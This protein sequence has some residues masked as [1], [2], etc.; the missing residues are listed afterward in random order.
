MGEETNTVADAMAFVD[1]LD[2]YVNPI[3]NI[4]GG[5]NYAPDKLP[6]LLQEEIVRAYNTA[7]RRHRGDLRPKEKWGFKNPRHIFL[8]PLLDVTF[9][10]VI[11]IHL[12]RDGRDMLF[13]DNKRQVEAHFEALFGE[14]FVESLE[15]VAR[16]WASTNLGAKAYG[17]MHLGPRY[18]NIRIEDLCGPERDTHIRRL[19]GALEL[20]VET[21]LIRA[22]RFELRDSYGRGRSAQL[23]LSATVRN[24]FFNAL[25]AFN[26]PGAGSAEPG[27]AV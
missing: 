26:Y 15:A 12:V 8:L 7:A 6:A 3:L 2:R 13:S 24:E 22:E 25:A 27:P 14:P 16:F 5:T 21:A 18:I 17:E 4:T 19:A 10:G 11:F 1:M 9:P 23:E 20:D